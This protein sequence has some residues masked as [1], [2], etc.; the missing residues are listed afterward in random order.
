[1]DNNLPKLEKDEFYQFKPFRVPKYQI[2]FDNASRLSDIQ[3]YKW[4]TPAAL[5]LWGRF[6]ESTLS[7]IV[8]RM[9]LKVFWY[10]FEQP[11]FSGFAV[12]GDRS[13]DHALWA[14]EEDQ[15][16]RFVDLLLEIVQF[17]I[18]NSCLYHYA[19][20]SITVLDPLNV[21][22]NRIATAATPEV[23]ISTFAVLTNKGQYAF[24][25]SFDAKSSGLP[26]MASYP[27]NRRHVAAADK[28]FSIPGLNQDKAFESYKEVINNSQDEE[29]LKEAQKKHNERISGHTK[30]SGK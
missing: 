30:S 6:S 22:S 10:K 15:W 5:Y 21:E 19:L 2:K 28:L 4:Y 9:D 3:G 11:I 13:W 8:Q 12:G 18:P 29:Y 1:M 25:S 14:C 20:Q 24:D 7:D 16:S 23:K 17:D 27:P 26:R